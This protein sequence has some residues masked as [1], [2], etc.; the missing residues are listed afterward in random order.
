MPIHFLLGEDPDSS[1]LVT[2][3]ILE[4][5]GEAVRTYATDPEAAGD[6]D[7]SEIDGLEAGLNTV[8]WDFRHEPMTAVEDLMRYGSA[9]GRMASPGI[10]RIRLTVGE[11]TAG[12]DVRLIPD[13][14]WDATDAEYREQDAFLARVGATADQL[15]ASVNR[16]R[17]VRDQVA[18]V[19]ERAV[20]IEG[21]DTLR[22]VGDSLTA[23]LE[24]WETTVVQA[25]QETFQ[26]VINFQNRLDAQILH[27]FGSVDGTEP[28]VTEG[29]RERLADLE[30]EWS[31]RSDAFAALMDRLAAFNALIRE[32]EVPPVVIPGDDAP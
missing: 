31:E 23:D 11:T 24:T 16:G 26:D 6:E 15:Y 18:S 14:R 25:K 12:S 3:E 27:L 28:P 9:G 4:P 2:V 10:Y 30:E 20:E 22:A 7:Y 32:L 21:A 29:A 1:T 17:R 13:P 19:L 5:A 8:T